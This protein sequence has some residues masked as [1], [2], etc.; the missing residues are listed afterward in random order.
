MKNNVLNPGEVGVPGGRR[1]IL[2]ALIFSQ[3]VAA[4]TLHVERRIGQNVI[5][6][7]VW[8][9]VVVETIPLGDL[10]VNTAQGQIHL[11]QTPPGVIKFLPVN[12]DVAARFASVPVAG[13]V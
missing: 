12:A 7:E 1:A 13:R 2:P 5:R 4:P 3:A 9:A 11:G 10:A 6:L 8:E